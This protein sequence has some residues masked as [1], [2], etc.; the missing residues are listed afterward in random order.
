M[1]NLSVR[2]SAHAVELEQAYRAV[3][4]RTWLAP[5]F[6]EAGLAV[7]RDLYTPES[8]AA[9]RPRPKELEVVALLSGL[10]FPR[11][12]VDPLVDVQ[13]RISAVL[14][15]RLHYWVAPANFGLEYCGFKWPADSW[16]PAQLEVVQDTLAS[17]RDAGFRFTIGG[18]QVNPDG[19]VVAKGFDDGEAIVRMRR[20]LRAAIPFLPQKQ[21]A[22]AHVPM[23]RILEPLGGERFAALRDLM[24]TLADADVA[25]TRIESLKL[26]HETRWYMEEKTILA[27]YALGDG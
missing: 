26:V 7:S 12:V 11:H 2:M 16:S 22:W 14:G 10:P 5:D 23:G 17:A 13:Q 19:C 4:D 1:P 15:P 20:R 9:R 24:Q 8:L 21:S 27:E 3:G 6:L 18:I 25:A